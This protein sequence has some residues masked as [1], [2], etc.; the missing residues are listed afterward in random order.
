MY[1]KLNL[2]KNVTLS[3]NQWLKHA[4]FY[5]IKCISFQHCNFISQSRVNKNTVITKYW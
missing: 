2:R 4:F 3:L 1:L 5:S